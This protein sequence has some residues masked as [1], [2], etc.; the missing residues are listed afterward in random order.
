LQPIGA[1]LAY[2][3]TDGELLLP[4]PVDRLS[5]THEV[6]DFLD[7]PEF[8]R[9]KKTVLIGGN[10]SFGARRALTF[11]GWNIIVRAPWPGAPPYAK[12][13]EPAAI[14]LGG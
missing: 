4:L 13:G 8:R 3:T 14:D 9:A 1:G 5:W 12:S 2:V 6:R 7:R 10:A 11:R